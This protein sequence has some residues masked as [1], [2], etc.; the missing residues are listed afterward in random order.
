M[1]WRNC[2]AISSFFFWVYVKILM[3]RI[4]LGLCLNAGKMLAFKKSNLQKKGNDT[5][6]IIRH[7]NCANNFILSVYLRCSF[8]FML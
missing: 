8:G 2:G 5:D 3:H 6:F 1:I 4:V 7:Y